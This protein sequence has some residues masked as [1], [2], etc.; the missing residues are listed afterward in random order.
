[1]KMAPRKFGEDGVTEFRMT[2]SSFLDLIN[3]RIVGNTGCWA[4]RE[5]GGD[6]KWQQKMVGSIT[7]GKS[8]F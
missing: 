8:N 3:G 6:S 7:S 5:N 1:M 4:G 2:V